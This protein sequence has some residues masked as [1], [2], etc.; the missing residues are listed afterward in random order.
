M[1]IEIKQLL[2]KSNVVDEE[3]DE[4]VEQRDMQNANIK[5]EVLSECRRLIVEMLNDKGQR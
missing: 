1:A 5:H 4:R 3:H 2:I